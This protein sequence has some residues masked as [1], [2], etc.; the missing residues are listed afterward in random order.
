[1]TQ[2][3]AFSNLKKHPIGTSIICLS[4]DQATSFL[5]VVY[6]VAKGKCEVITLER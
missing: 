4:E 3:E 1:M 6:T 2:A 5:S